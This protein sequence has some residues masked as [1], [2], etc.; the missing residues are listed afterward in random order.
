V[1]DQW[2]WCSEAGQVTPPM[3]KGIAVYFDARLYRAIKLK[4]DGTHCTISDLVN[5][6]LRL[7]LREDASDLQAIRDRANEP[8]RPL[9]DIL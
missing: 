7:S 1:L 9:E 4:A 8:S 2:N 5:E 6:A 3:M